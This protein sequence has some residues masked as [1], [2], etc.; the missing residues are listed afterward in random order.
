MTPW[1]DE[2]LEREMLADARLIEE[3]WIGGSHAADGACHI[4]ALLA[5][6][7]ELEAQATKLQTFKD[8][9]HAYLDAQGVPKEFPDGPHSRE[10][11]RVG[12]RMDWL[13]TRLKEE[14]DG[15]SQRID[16]TP[17]QPGTEASNQEGRNNCA[18]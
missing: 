3:D 15:T 2:N 7:R 12:D 18:P 11:C 6:V 10:G 1:P 16:P 4:K 17:V 8:W 13:V 5:R 14:K 9:V